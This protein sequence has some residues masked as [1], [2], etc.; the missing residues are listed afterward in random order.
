[1]P[2]VDAVELA[3]GD[4]P[5]PALDVGKPGD[6]HSTHVVHSDEVRMCGMGHI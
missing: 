3:H 2:E 5:R 4:V 1:M 6:L